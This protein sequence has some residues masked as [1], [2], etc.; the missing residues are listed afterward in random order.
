[1]YKNILSRT[2]LSK[3]TRLFKGSVDNVKQVHCAICLRNPRQTSKPNNQASPAITSKYQVITDS[4]ATVIENTAEEHFQEENK[5][6]IF[7]DEYDGVN[8]TRGKTGVF[9]IEDL[10]VLLQR[11]NSKDIFVATVP[12]SINYVDYICIVSA[13]SKRHILALAEFVRKVYKKKCY[14]SDS[15]PRIEGKGS[16]EWMALDLGNIALH[17]FSEKARKVYDLETLWAVGP[18]YDDQMN[19][20]HDVA[21]IFQNYSS[22]LKDLKPLS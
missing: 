8:L 20:K 1:M 13:R 16:D 5:Y 11:E 6:P 12:Q 21:D 22:Y 14:K 18:E 3:T 19:K 10:V 15:I 9:E 7:S 17:I 2:L 4:N